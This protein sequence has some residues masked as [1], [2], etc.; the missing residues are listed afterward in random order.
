MIKIKLQLISMMILLAFA[1]ISQAQT[2]TGVITDAETNEPLIGAA[3]SLDGTT[4]GAATNINGEYTLNV[5]ELQGTLVVR[6][7]GYVSQRIDIDGRD[8]IDIQLETDLY[9]L[10][11]VVMVGY[12][13]QQKSLVTGSISRLESRQI[14]AA[15]P[16]RVEQALQ[17][18]S[19]GVIVL[20]NS[21]QPGSGATVRIRGAGTTG[22]ANPLYV[23]DGMPVGGI[24]YL[25]PSD[26]ESIEVLKDAS[27]TAIYGAR[28]ANGVVVIT[29]KSGA[30]GPI[31][32]S[33]NGYYGTQAP[34]K[35]T[36]LL[37][38]QDYM[39]IMNE[40]YE[41]DGRRI[42]FPDDF[43]DQFG[44]TKE[45]IGAGT[46][47]QQEVFSFSAPITN[48]ELS[49]SGGNETSTFFSS[50]SY[51]QQDGIVAPS[52]SNYERVT[53]RL[54]S[55][56]QK[57]RLRF[58][59]RLAYTN[60]TTR[61][62]DPNESFA[63]IMSR[64]ANIDPVTPVYEPGTN[65]FAQSPFAAQEIVNP[66]AA[67][68]IINGMWRE[69]K[70]VG[71]I[72]GDISILEKLSFRSSFDI[73]LAYG[74]NRFFNPV[75]DLGGNTSNLVSNTGMQQN[76]WFTWQTSQ[77]MTYRDQ[78]ADH[79]F[80][81]LGG[82]EAR[83]FRYELLGGTKSDL[84]FDSFE[85][86]WINTGQD[87]ESMVVF[88]TASE[89]SLASYFA[90]VNYDFAGRYMLEG[91]IRA[92]GSS[93]FGPDDRWG[94]FPAFSLGW[95]ISDEDFMDNTSN[96]SFLKLR[97]GWGQNG[98]DNIG[99]FNYTSL[100]AAYSGY[101]FGRDPS[102]VTGSYP[103]RIA[104][105]NL[106]WETSEQA[107]IGI[108]SGF[109]DDRLLITADFYQKN[110]RGLLLEA[111]I[112]AF[113]GNQA[114][115]VN[116]G[117]VQNTGTELE[118]IYRE[119]SSSFRYSIGLSGAYN[120]NEVTSINNEEGRL[121]G[122]NAGLGMNNVA[123]A[124]VG[125]PIAFFWGFETAGIFQ[126]QEEVDAHVDA[127]G[128]PIQ[129]NAQPGDLIF[130][131]Q[132]GDGVL[133]NQDRVMI[134][135]PYPDFTAGLNLDF[136]WNNF[137]FN[138]FWYGAFGMDVFT[139]ATRRQDLVLS[140]WKSSVL[141]RWTEENPSTTHPRVTVRD[142]NGNYSRPS[143][144]FVEN[145]SY[146]RLRNLTLGYTIP[147]NITSTAGVSR[148]RVYISAQNL[149]TFTSYSGHDPE[150]GSGWA[151]DVGIDRNIYPQART[152]MLGINLDI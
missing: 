144:F 32:I 124:Q 114:P 119:Q 42:P 35:T 9:S 86:A 90:R 29:T 79:S 147:S 138:M 1:G 151:L 8:Q 28:G 100:I 39:M 65:N 115:I 6:Y 148:A 131:D 92:D 130:V 14:E 98:S 71:S 52:K 18:R 133:D 142:R 120:K 26:I 152:F 61:G 146:V 150:I 132:N 47:W 54:N 105:P 141:D 10:G 3:I 70:L 21:G 13:M 108:E 89:E 76:K 121:F 17:G 134:G 67:I 94:I 69:D 4:I 48:H 109:W 11:E 97:G 78:I 139:G 112:P 81:V 140:N 53:F 24:D 41:N 40:S 106:R 19:P 62:I 20:Q 5:P 88:G 96:L 129:P 50:L 55:D 127:E 66:V 27:A 63:G 149:I 38:A 137:D 15:A 72:Y 57:G 125:F 123:M 143:D 91:V 44:R 22:D 46:D 31:K 99:Q 30:R 117:S 85:N 102:R 74:N 34:W 59:N 49:L 75:Y 60:K 80:S 58:G 93:K 103:S 37:D 84:L 43:V 2:I 23:V 95:I 7:I 145:A 87:E 16:L 136:N 116:G 83:N 110:T 33:Y 36:D 56:H 51:R 45:E 25:N 118:I 107:N 82:F 126:S 111:P 113:I 122:A 104:N 128:N 135:D 12:G 64:V 73:D 68:D 101:S 77:V